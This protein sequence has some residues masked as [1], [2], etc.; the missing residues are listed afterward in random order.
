MSDYPFPEELRARYEPRVELGRGGM[1]VVFLAHDRKLD[2]EVVVK[3]SQEASD[4]SAFARAQREAQVLAQLE[5]PNV[6]RVYD[7]GRTTDGP[8]LV[9]EHL[10][11]RSLD[12]LG[13]GA[14]LGPIFRQLADGLQ[15]V[16][17]AGLL[18]R[19]L[20]PAN[21]FLEDAGRALLIDFGLVR[22]S[23]RTQLT[24]T[25]QVLGTRAYM[26]PECLRGE[27]ATTASDWYGWAAAF[28][29][30]LEGRSPYST[31]QLIKHCTEGAP[32][33]LRF[34]R[35]PEI[36]R[37]G[38][39]ALLDPDPARR[40]KRP[41]EELWKVLSPSPS[42][43][44]EEL[45]ALTSTPIRV[46]DRDAMRAAA[47][48][49]S[50]PPSP[51]PRGGALAAAALFLVAVG[52]GMW[53]RSSYSSPASPPLASVPAQPSN[54]LSLLV[55]RRLWTVPGENPLLQ[56]Y[57]QVRRA[58]DDATR[59]RLRNIHTPS[60][61]RTWT[62]EGLAPEVLE[63]IGP[64]VNS[65]RQHDPRVLDEIADAGDLTAREWRGLL[66]TLAALDALQQFLHRAKEDLDLGIAAKR[67]RLL[68]VKVEPRPVSVGFGGSEVTRREI[69]DGAGPVEVRVVFRPD[70]QGLETLCLSFG[71]RY[72]PVLEGK[73]ATYEK[74]SPFVRW[75]ARLSP[76]VLG[77]ARSIELSVVRIQNM[78]SSPERL[79]PAGEELYA[80]EV[81]RLPP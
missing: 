81:L 43:A 32:L 27:T 41:P 69:P 17:A 49:T 16:H 42:A 25:G 61:R 33:E 53:W 31:P 50:P 76:E 20:K 51:G 29:A 13:A 58:W 72:Y 10:V 57:L 37:G 47:L 15:A 75:T 70:Y 60:Q 48:S 14:A 71:E 55:R 35:T 8:Y 80:F 11:G 28:F 45:R 65:V 9:T 6:L 38:L 77:E 39:Q 3:L 21:M 36:A 5:H 52:A 63:R 23:R 7:A 4:P 1:G 74:P 64:L 56:E 46:L 12:A 73:E 34:E 59:T 19:D 79:R 26:A 40:P 68:P 24:R 54:P 78:E 67:Q 18:H 2:R 62:P 22:D 66:R 30:C 44:P